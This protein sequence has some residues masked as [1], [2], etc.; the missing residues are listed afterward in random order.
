[1][2][3]DTQ[4]ATSGRKIIPWPVVQPMAGGKS[5]VQIR[6][7]VK[8]G[9]FPAPVDLSSDGSGRKVGWYEDEIVAWQEKLKRRTYGREEGEDNACATR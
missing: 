5:R 4:A 1:M 3:S 8:A 9:K 2:E 7:D 6:R